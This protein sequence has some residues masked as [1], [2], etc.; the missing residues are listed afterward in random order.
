MSLIMTGSSKARASGEW[1]LVGV[2][3]EDF[4][5]ATNTRP[6]LIDAQHT[7]GRRTRWVLKPLHRLGVGDSI[8]ELVAYR[9]AERFGIPIP[10]YGVVWV[11]DECVTSLPEPLRA[12]LRQTLGPNFGTRFVPGLSD[13]TDTL[14]IPSAQ[15][16]TACDI[17]AF[18]VGVDNADRRKGNP[19]LLLGDDQ[20]LAIDHQHAFSWCSSLT[21][22]P[23]EW[24]PDVL[25]R[26]LSEHF[27][28]DVVFRWLTSYAEM[29]ARGKGLNTQDA[30][31]L[32]SQLPA[33]WLTQGG[34]HY[35]DRIRDFLTDLFTRWDDVVDRLEGKGAA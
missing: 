30:L 33:E 24:S 18:D 8:K 10:E 27:L 7:S 34:D 14:A 15:R 12:G 35:R 16:S 31:D 11:S 29:R 1:E 17:F 3:S 32:T 22:P 21:T 5:G 13:V 23:D 28:A 2:A 20:V 19:N 25:R 6:L 26:L 9:L 4:F